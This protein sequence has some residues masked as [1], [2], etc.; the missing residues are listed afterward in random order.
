MGNISFRSASFVALS[1]F[2]NSSS[3]P[4]SSDVS[5]SPMDL[6]PL[7]KLDISV[8]ASD[9]VGHV[10][11]I[12]TPL[13]ETLSKCALVPDGS[14][15]LASSSAADVFSMSRVS[16]A[17]FTEASSVR[18]KSDNIADSKAS[19]IGG[20]YSFYIHGQIVQSSVCFVGK[21]TTSARYVSSIGNTMY[22]ERGT[23]VQ[24]Y[25]LKRVI[26]KANFVWKHGGLSKTMNA[27][28]HLW[29]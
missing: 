6:T 9:L 20:Q 25:A 19:S 13:S 12:D 21:R 2:S 23:C 28:K 17:F 7:D 3:C 4:C 27:L 22:S 14:K 26:K 5:D 18:S 24:S 10:P 1:S 11:G 16:R 29:I 15:S 8:E